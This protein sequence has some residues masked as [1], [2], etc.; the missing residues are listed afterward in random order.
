MKQFGVIGLGRFG[1]SVA[2]TLNE[3][4]YQ[5]LAIDINEDAVQL[6]SEYVTQAIQMDGTDKKALASIGMNNVDV[7]VVGIGDKIEAS[8][9][10][11]LSLKELG[12][13]EII[14]KA[15]TENHGKV[16]ERVGATKVVFPE[17]DMGVR[18]ANS[19]IYPKVLENIGLSSQCSILEIIA[20]KD[21]VGK[22]L[23]ELNLRAQYGLNI[24]AIK[25]KKKTAE[26]SIDISPNPEKIIKEDDIL[27]LIGSAN[28][29]DSLKEKKR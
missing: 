25:D 4:N 2:R 11:T 16:L 1:S 12:I 28:N 3:K 15:I 18:I 27:I 6:A 9:L 26:E 17:R 14:S 13:K 5:V 24:I 19:L 8:I 10:I 23:K 20:P 21:F 7:A 29:I 22:N